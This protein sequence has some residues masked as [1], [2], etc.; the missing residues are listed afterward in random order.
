MKLLNILAISAV[1]G[2]ASFTVQA[3]KVLVVLSDASELELKNGRSIP[4]GFYF[5]E[6]MQPVK[7][8]LD[9]G[10]TLTFATPLGRAPTM[11]QGSFDKSYFGGSN[12]ALNDHKVLMDRLKIT[13][14]TDSPVVS[15]SRI[16]QVGYA[17]FDALYVPG[18]ACA[19]TG[20]SHRH[21]DGQI[22][23]PLSSV[24]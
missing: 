19:F 1:V 13:S 16:E 9:A 7:M 23:H 8:L 21:V 20:F 24:R 10:H 22:T 6:L 11:D 4:T 2:G 5:N 15:L 17:Q 12:E 18:G 3:A 14:L